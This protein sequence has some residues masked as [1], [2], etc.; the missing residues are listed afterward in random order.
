MAHTFQCIELT[1]DRDQHPFHRSQRVDGQDSQRR[2]AVD[3][4]IVIVLP[5]TVD[6]LLQT[7]LS[8]LQLYQ[9]DFRACQAHVSRNQIQV[10][11]SGMQH[12]SPGVEIFV[13]QKLIHRILQRF[14]GDSDPT[15]GIPLRVD[16][17]HQDLLPHLRQTRC[18]I[19]IGRG[20]SYAT[21]LVKYS[22]CLSQLKPPASLLSF[23]SLLY[24]TS[25]DFT[26]VLAKN[27]SR[28]TIS[29]Y[30]LSP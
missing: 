22:D 15:G 24:P 2:R 7:L 28:E 20:L 21:F 12:H 26:T 30:F 3:Q 29:D 9:L 16:I 27:V 11:D 1:L 10:R 5:D 25:Q 13:H 8:S 4:N 19:D 18:K 6:R 23:F 14:L 17:Q